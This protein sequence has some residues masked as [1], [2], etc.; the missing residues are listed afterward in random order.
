MRDRYICVINEPLV[1]VVTY[2]LIPNIDVCIWFKMNKYLFLNALKLLRDDNTIII[3][4]A[5]I[6]N[7]TVIMNKYDYE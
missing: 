2:W 1:T 7:T 5:D 6:G 4:R 3:T